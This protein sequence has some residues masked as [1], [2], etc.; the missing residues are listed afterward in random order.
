MQV[1]QE[2]RVPDTLPVVDATPMIEEHRYAV[3]DEFNQNSEPDVED[4]TITDILK[5]VVVV[6]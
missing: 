3:P 4:D 1:L 2:E 5:S 6:L